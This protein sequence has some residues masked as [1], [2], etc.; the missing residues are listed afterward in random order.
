[1][2][3]DSVFNGVPE[4]VASPGTVQAPSLGVDVSVPSLYVSAGK[5]WQ[6]VG[7]GGGGGNVSGTLTPGK[8]PIAT[9]VHTL[10]DGPIDYGVA[11][12]GVLTIKNTV[13]GVF[14]ESTGADAAVELFN[15]GSGGTLIVDAGGDGISI[16]ETAIGGITLATN[17]EVSITS[18]GDITSHD[19]VLQTRTQA[20]LGITSGAETTDNAGQITLVAGTGT[21]TWANG[22]EAGG[23][24]STAPIV[25]VMDLT[26]P[27]NISNTV[28]T[29]TATDLT[30]TNAVNTTDV[31]N[32]I[33]W[34]TTSG[35]VS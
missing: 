3:F 10:G 29:V 33:A 5:G 30:I 4:N 2:A 24:W 35:G 7:A 8:M 23:A 18:G 31:Y 27:A 12:T 14:V 13:N 6:E 28:V 16:S 19:I 1:M 20:P 15:N 17:G 34:P 11:Y 22:Q 21:Y 25:V 9:D 26:N 32:W